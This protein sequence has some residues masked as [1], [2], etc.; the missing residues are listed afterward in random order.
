MNRTLALLLLVSV[1]LPARAHEPELIP[2]WL[3][4]EIAHVVRY[5]SPESRSEI[6][7]ILADAGGDY[8][9]WDTGR[10]A[11]LRELLVNEGL[12]VHVSRQMSPGHAEWEYYGY[13]RRQYARVRELETS[14]RRVI[15][16]DLNSAG[17][18]LRLKYLS[19]GMSDEARTVERVVMPERAGY[20]LGAR[21]VEPAIAARGLPWAVRASAD[22]LA[23]AAGAVAA[24]A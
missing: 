6:R 8:S 22:E 15:E 14:M 19:G 3:S 18:G 11:S 16:P 5:T 7:P 17:L 1:A 2:M 24:S 21:L 9:Y 10:R 23:Q 20:Y 12:A 13:Q 4:H